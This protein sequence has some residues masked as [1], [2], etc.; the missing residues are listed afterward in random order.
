MKNILVTDREIDPGEVIKQL[1]AEKGFT[2]RQL[3]ARSGTSKSGLS[4]WE[5]GARVPNVD[6]YIRILKA[7]DADLIVTREVK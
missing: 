7:L 4:R 1:R 6:A 3:A 5:N 2:L